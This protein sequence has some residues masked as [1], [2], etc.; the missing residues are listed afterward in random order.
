M[1]EKLRQ[2]GF[3]AAKDVLILSPFELMEV[4]DIHEEDAVALLQSVSRATV[5]APGTV[6]L[7]A[8]VSPYALPVEPCVLLQKR[9][10]SA[11]SKRE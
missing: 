8:R 1:H 10:Q 11:S 4:L 6:C 7:L 9:N 2:K 5:P 3:F